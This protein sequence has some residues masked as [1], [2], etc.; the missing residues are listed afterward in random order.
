MLRFRSS[1]IVASVAIAAWACPSVVRADFFLH[2]WDD[3]YEPP[4]FLRLQ[5]TAMYYNT[6]SNF[7]AQGLTSQPAGLSQYTRIQSDGLVSYGIFNR[8]SAFGR[9]S[10]AYVNQLSTLTPGNG[11]GFGDQTGGLCYRILGQSSNLTHHKMEPAIDLQAQIDFPAYSTAVSVANRTPNLGD[12]TL[13]IT[14]G[15]FLHL[16]ITSTKSQVLSTL[17]G[18]GYTFRNGGFSSAVPWSARMDYTPIKSG[19]HF[20]AGGVG[21]L[22]LQNDVT[23]RTSNGT[24]GSFIS[25]AMN[26]AIFQLQGVVGYKT[27]AL[28]EISA[29]VTQSVWGLSSPNGLNLWLRFQT[30]L[31]HDKKDSPTSLSPQSYGES[32]QGFV[33][34]SLDAKVLR[35]NDRLNLVKI[36]KG[37][38]DGVEVGQLFDLFPE[39]GGAVARAK[40][41]AVK[42]GES[43]LEIKEYYKEVWIDEGFVAR[44]LVGEPGG[45]E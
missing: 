39:T 18:G 20:G 19:F 42:V 29:T 45:K 10:W 43:A 34:Y 3:Q 2:S 25:G 36:D 40:V 5:V 17:M 7:T 11:F 4:S 1:L 32:N 6:N 26:P 30:Q 28:T 38:Q 37:S 23:L 16:P 24:G 35:T 12:G 33:T 27:A 9:F 15:A 13:D 8:F 31:G 22:S 14:G 44:R 41:S 21:N